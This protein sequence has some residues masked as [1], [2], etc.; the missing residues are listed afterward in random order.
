MRFPSLDRLLFRPSADEA[1]RAL[2]DMATTIV[3][4]LALVIG[5]TV[6]AL[7]GGVEPVLELAQPDWKPSVTNPPPAEALQVSRATNGL[8]SCPLVA[9]LRQL[10]PSG[11][12]QRC[13][14]GQAYRALGVGLTVPLRQQSDAG[15]VLATQ[16][17]SGP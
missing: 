11:A 4:V 7:G 17:R 16:W 13:L 12:S 9:A 14:D 5:L 1:R 10:H 8:S 2:L 15:S 3:G 6:V